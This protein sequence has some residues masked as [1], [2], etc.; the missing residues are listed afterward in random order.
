MR[1]ARSGRCRARARCRGAAT[2]CRARG[3]CLRAARRP[4]LRGARARAAAGPAARSSASVPSRRSTAARSSPAPSSASRPSRTVRASASAPAVTYASAAWSSRRRRSSACAGGV[5]CAASVSSSAPAS[6]AP[7]AS[8]ASAAP[9]SSAATGSSGPVAPSARWRARVS[10]SPATSASSRC[11]ARRAS[12]SAQASTAA[13]TSGLPNETRS[14]SRVITPAAAAA[15][16]AFRLP[17]AVTVGCASRCGGEQCLPG[18]AR[19]VVQAGCE[20]RLEA[21]GERQP[22][23][24][25]ETRPVTER[26]GELEGVERVAAARFVDAREQGPRQRDPEA[27]AHEPVQGGGVERPQADA[28]VLGGE[29]RGLAGAYR[30]Q[31]H[32][33][34]CVESAQREG[35]RVRGLV[36]EPVRVVHGHEHRAL[37][38]KEAQAVEDGQPDSAPLGRRPIRVLEQERDLER[39]AP[40]RRQP[41]QHVREHGREQ[42]AERGKGQLDLGACRAAGQDASMGGGDAC[43][44]DGRL[45]DPRLA[46]DDDRS[47]RRGEEVG[48]RRELGLT[49]EDACGGH[50]RRIALSRYKSADE[51]T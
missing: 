33:G 20:Q 2:R 3:G 35:Q 26:A 16:S 41:R 25:V 45:A 27:V 23:A 38:G 12:G 51:R 37:L 21:R 15:S 22:L 40:R 43:L 34:L 28:G 10:A 49:A 39:A 32:Y 4:T 48:N 13:A 9:S 6:G 24:R 44:P 5:S 8:A 50:E 7:R 19:Q 42:V 30:G 29:R 14:P 17:I 31:D 36:V 47:R 18:L 46:L 1:A 11:I